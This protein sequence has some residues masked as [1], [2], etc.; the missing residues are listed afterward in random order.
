MVSAKEE[1]K[2]RY[3]HPRLT[4][5]IFALDERLR[6]H[7]AIVEYSSHASCIFRLHIAQSS[8]ALTLRDGTQIRVGQ[9]MAELHFWNAHIPPAWQNG[10]TIRWARKMQK[11]I[12]TSLCELVRYLAS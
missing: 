9:R 4:E 5:V 11:N 3:S 8:R 6:R 7:Q 12:S 2:S 1:V 10:A